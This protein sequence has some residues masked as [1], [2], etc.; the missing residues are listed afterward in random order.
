MNVP[1]LLDADFFE[2]QIVKNIDYLKEA[3]YYI[4][5]HFD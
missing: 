1:H 2:K 3:R 4:V 5:K